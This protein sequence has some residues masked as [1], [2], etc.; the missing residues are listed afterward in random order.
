MP[1]RQIRPNLFSQWIRSCVSWPGC[2][3]E[4]TGKPRVGRPV[5]W[6]MACRAEARTGLG[7]SERDRRGA[8]GNAASRSTST[9]SVRR[10]SRLDLDSRSYRPAT[11][12]S[13]NND[14]ARASGGGRSLPEGEPSLHL[15]GTGSPAIRD[16]RPRRLLTDTSHAPPTR[17]CQS[18]PPSMPGTLATRRLRR[19]A[20]TRAGP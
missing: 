8:T 3:G 6:Q 20:P 13:L 10:A 18:D 5:L 19:S 7:K 2:C 4:D 12:D 1:G 17:E 14:R 16:S 15:C 9:V 11:A